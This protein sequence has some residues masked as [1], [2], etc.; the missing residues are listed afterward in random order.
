MKKLKT[1]LLG[2]LFSGLLLTSS[3]SNNENDDVVIENTKSFEQQILELP[4][5]SFEGTELIKLYAEAMKEVLIMAKEPEFRHFVYHKSLDQDGGDYNVYL[6]DMVAKYK[7]LGKFTKST[8]KLLKLSSEIK[9]ANGGLRPIVFFP[10]AETIEDAIREGKSYNIAKSFVEPVAV[11]KGAYNNDY[12]VPGYTL[13]SNGDLIYNRNV[14]E[15]DA[16]ENDVYVIGEEEI[17]IYDSD[18]EF[19]VAPDDLNGGG[20]GSGGSGS[21]NIRTDS[22][23]EHGG[24]V[25][26]TDLNAIEHWF[27][28]KLEFKLVVT[29]VSGS[30][31]TVIRNLAYP[32]RRRK[33]FKNQAWY[34]YGTFLFNW[35]KSNL[36]NWNVESW[37]ELDGG[38]SSEVTITMP[39]QNGAPTTSVKIPSQDRDDNLGS[40]I[41]QFTDR[42]D[43]AYPISYMNFKRK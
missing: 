3:C 35:N 23:A 11:L 1:P 2:L 42:L 41:V 17:I 9:S 37:F 30:A 43:Q 24:L 26:V 38:K 34:D 16:W 5:N 40:S 32:K 28:G 8:S 15:E 33:N 20:G 31:G 39:G 12:S 27:S 4:H 6:D 7:K 14:T 36:G 13:N 18:T 25:Q 29:G 10:K 22:R 21:S 19:I